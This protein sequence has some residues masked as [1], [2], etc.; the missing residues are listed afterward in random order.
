[1]ESVA[2]ERVEN[3]Y[4]ILSCCGFAMNVGNLG[5]GIDLPSRLRGLGGNQW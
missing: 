2:E 5:S 4:H 1:M 3:R